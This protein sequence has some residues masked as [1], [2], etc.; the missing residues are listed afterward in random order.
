MYVQKLLLNENFSSSYHGSPDVN[1]EQH[2]PSHSI[3][4]QPGGEG[5]LV[6][7]V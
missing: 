2:I 4:I 6:V 1:T 7:D 3:Y 5:D